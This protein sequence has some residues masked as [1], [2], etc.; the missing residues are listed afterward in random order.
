M[1]E[2][3]DLVDA[4]CA[5]LARFDPNLASGAQCATLA[6]RLA[7]AANAC[8]AG[9]ARAAARAVDCGTRRDAPAWLARVGGASASTARTALE[10]VRQLDA[11]PSTQRAL[12]AGEVSLAQAAEI[13]SVPA[14]ETELLDLARAAGLGAVKNKARTRRLEAIDPE[15]LHARQ[16]AA[17]EFVHWRDQLGMTRFRGA[18]P[19]EL[20]VPFVNR[21]DAA[22]DREWRADHQAGQA[23]ARPVLA[24]RAFTQLLAGRTTGKSRSAELVIVQDLRAYRRGHAHPGEVSHVI[25]GGPIPVRIARELAQDA[26]LKAV[27]HDGKAIHTVAHFGR[28]RPAHLDTA[29]LLGNPPDFEGAVCD[30]EGCDRR[31]GLEFDHIDPV[32]NGG[33]TSLDNLRPVCPPDHRDKT[34]RDRKAGRLGRPRRARGP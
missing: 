3:V 33:R 18:L 11:C 7:R 13:V 15:E 14:H 32:A 9:S 30:V 22:T 23:T 1:R 26:F 16:H 5:A 27:L 2:L 21:L 19:P 10:T 34:E 6:E 4:L 28:R 20:G 24:A 8:E 31:Y 12:V 25:G 29:L 17:Q